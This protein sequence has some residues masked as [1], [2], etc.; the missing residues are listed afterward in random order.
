MEHDVQYGF[1]LS[2]GGARGVVQLGIMQ[3]L[4]EHDIAPSVIAGT[5]M[6]AINGLFLAD[7]YTPKETYEILIKNFKHSVYT[8]RWRA[9]K[10]GFVNLIPMFKKYIQATCFEELKMP[11]YVS[12][13]N[14]NTGKNEIV[15]AGTQ[16]FDFVV[17]SASIPIVF[18]PHVIN[19]HHY[20]DGGVSNNF[21][22][23]V[24]L[25]KCDKIVGIH[26]NHLSEENNIHNMFGVVERIY[27]IAIH[28]VIADR[29]EICDYCFDPEEIMKYSM[30]DFDKMTEIYKLGY[31]LGR[32]FVKTHCVIE[33]AS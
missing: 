27:R 22:T 10:K 30:F 14:L 13:T 3:A 28:S 19:G 18:P 11:F 8:P 15:S 5:S 12:A 20:V 32:D 9:V 33:Q 29:F 31:A 4:R 26:V 2:G 21:P 25:G 7:G 1:S 24:L 23:A 17:A 16:L 6:G